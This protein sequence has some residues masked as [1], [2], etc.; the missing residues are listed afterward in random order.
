MS[1]QEQYLPA[2]RPGSV[3]QRRPRRRA[4]VQPSDRR[5]NRRG[6]WS[7]ARCQIVRR[8]DGLRGRVR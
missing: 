2:S 8:L 7:G 1:E 3:Y 4:P 5:D 6:L